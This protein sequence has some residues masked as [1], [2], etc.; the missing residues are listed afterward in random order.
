[1]AMSWVLT[2]V[3]LICSG[4]A[5][6][7][8][9]S[10][11]NAVV[12]T[13]VSLPVPLSQFPFEL[14]NWTGRDIPV[15]ATVLKV[16]GND[17]YFLRSYTNTATGQRANVYVGY[18]ARPRTMRGHRPAICYPNAGWVWDSTALRTVLLN[19][20]RQI[21]SLVHRFHR[22]APRTAETVVLNFYILN[23]RVT[24]D[25]GGFSGL[26]WRTP[27][28]DGDPARYVSQVQ[29]S[30]VMESSVLAATRDLADS[31]LRFF[32]ETTSPHA[33]TRTKAP[34]SAGTH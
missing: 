12:G 5:H 20:G 11:L 13:P 6:R 4:I 16:A 21:T 3:L 10:R 1:M 7:L 19:S 28:I 15:S 32:P 29:I 17:D 22:P 27:N 34:R 25:E 18:S 26:G 8:A 31:I 14:A 2:V 30:S 33:P 9:A 24:A 23:G